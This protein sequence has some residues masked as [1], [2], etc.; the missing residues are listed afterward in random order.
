[1]TAR[2]RRNVSPRPRPPPARLPA[3]PRTPRRPAIWLS[4]LARSSSVDLRGRARPAPAPA[5]ALGRLL[6]L[7][8]DG[9]GEPLLGVAQPLA[10]FGLLARGGAQ[11]LAVGGRFARLGRGFGALV[12]DGRG[13]GRR[14]CARAPDILLQRRRIRQ[15]GE[16]LLGGGDGVAGRFQHRLEIGL[17]LR[18][19]RRAAPRSARA[20]PPRHRRPVRRRAHRVSA[21]SAACAGLFGLASAIAPSPRGPRRAPAS[22]CSTSAARAR[23]IRPPARQPVGAQQPLGGSGA[24]ADRDEP[25]PAPQ[26]PVASDQPLAD[27]K[28]LAR[29]LRRRPRPAAAAAASSA[30]AVDVIGEAVDAVREAGI[31]GQR[32]RCPASGAAIRRRSRR[33]HPR[34]AP[35][36]ARVHIPARP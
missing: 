34:R 32:A 12:G 35:P 21:A 13:G 3:R 5:G 17:P 9:L 18:R 8:L 22:A 16:R 36:R 26:S 33:R 1:M 19:A 27:R 20:R 10:P 28:R 4:V 25:V 24:G 15:G 14:R 29:C 7:P 30:G 31:V 2:W 23:A 6:L 11:P